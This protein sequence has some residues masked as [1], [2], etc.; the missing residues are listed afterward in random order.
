MND[1]E[2]VRCYRRKDH[3][4]AFCLTPQ[5]AQTIL[6]MMGYSDTKNAMCNAYGDGRYSR[7]T[8]SGI[9]YGSKYGQYSAS[10]GDYILDYDGKY[11][12]A[13]Y[14]KEKFAKEFCVCSD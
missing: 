7:I 10:F 2:S 6:D 11:S 4:T 9:E 3:M 5:N 8:D 13:V 14:K 1:V 12:W